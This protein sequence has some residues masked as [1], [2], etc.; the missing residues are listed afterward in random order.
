MN[1]LGRIST[2]QTLDGFPIWIRRSVHVR[3]YTDTKYI[4][5]I[6]KTRFSIAVYEVEQTTL[7]R[8]RMKNNADMDLDNAMVYLNFKLKR[9]K[10]FYMF[11]SIMT[12]F[13]TRNESRKISDIFLKLRK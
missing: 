3:A 9:W 2:A 11:I 10:E 12:Y 4:P 5:P 1:C 8:E 13:V 7:D 6:D